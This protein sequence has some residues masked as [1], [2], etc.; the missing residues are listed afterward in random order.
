MQ[1][2]IKNE[3]STKIIV[4]EENDE[5]ITV[6]RL[7]IDKKQLL[8]FINCYLPTVNAPNRVAADFPVARKYEEY[9]FI[10]KGSGYKKVAVKDIICLEAARNYCDI[11]LVGGTC[12]NVSMPMSEVYEYLNPEYFKRVHRSFV[13]HLEH[14]DTYI[15][16]MLT[17]S[18]G[19]EIVVGREY[20]EAVSKEFI[21]IG[22]RKRVIEKRGK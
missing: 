18:S 11:H 10:R 17:L 8:D 9:V 3:I 7:S 2:K 6:I 5:E 1:E 20:R 14:V 21:C 15:G 19:K 13:I 22:S 4:I 16:N 12:L